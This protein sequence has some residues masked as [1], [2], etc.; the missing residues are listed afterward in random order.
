MTI[1]QLIVSFILFTTLIRADVGITAP[2][3]GKTYDLSD[4][5]EVQIQIKW[6]DVGSI[7][8]NTDIT[9]YTFSLCAGPNGNIENMAT[10]G[11]VTPSEVTGSSY[12][13]TIQAT[14][15]TDGQYY[16]QIFAQTASGYTIHY[17]PRF[18][19][20]GMKGAKVAESA[21][22][23]VPPVAQT[24]ITTGAVVGVIDSRSFT[25]PYTK[26]TGIVRYAP[27]QTQPPTKVTMG[28]WTTK[29]PTSAVTYYSTMRK[30]IDQQTTVTPGWS[31]NVKS[32]VN[33]A[34]VAPM[35]SDNGGWYDPKERMTLTTR[36][37]NLRKRGYV[38]GKTGA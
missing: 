11:T 38:E 8:K 5:G 6:T 9:K 16:I 18:T 28:S 21:A 31:Y 25:V 19:L 20:K 17:T 23:T 34:S 14:M 33:Y 10:L 7:P 2:T 35:P 12:E 29:F 32:G 1:Y 30:S 4:S 36:K 24:M 26:Q 13:A 3:A 27:M 22:D 37:I 15:G